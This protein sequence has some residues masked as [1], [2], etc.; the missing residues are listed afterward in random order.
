MDNIMTSML[1]L[2][3]LSTFEGWPTYLTWYQDGSATG[4]IRNSNSIF[5]LYFIFFMFIGTW[6]L[7][8]LFTGV[9]SLNY[10]LAEKKA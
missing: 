6:F 5:V 10:Q 7:M 1:T 4:P 8:S 2:Y 3:V 9:L